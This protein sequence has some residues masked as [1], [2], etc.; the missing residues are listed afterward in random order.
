MGSH[1]TLY[2]SSKNG[3]KIGKIWTSTLFRYEMQIL[4]LVT[5]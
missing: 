5:E 1:H 3:A 4:S 2:D